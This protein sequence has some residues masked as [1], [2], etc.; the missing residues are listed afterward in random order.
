MTIC[1]SKEQF[2]ILNPIEPTAIAGPVNLIYACLFSVTKNVAD[3]RLKLFF[4]FVFGATAPSGPGFP[5]SRR[6]YITHNEAP[7]SVGLLWKGDQLVAET[8]T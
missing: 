5:H 4:F 7:Q 8:S 2:L 6:F 3:Y 1:V